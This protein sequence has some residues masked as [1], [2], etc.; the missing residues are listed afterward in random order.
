[1]TSSICSVVSSIG[2]A[3]GSFVSSVGTFIGGCLD[4]IPSIV[5]IIADFAGNLLQSLGIFKPDETPDKMGEKA[6]QAAEKGIRLDDFKDFDAYMEKLRAFEIDP[7]VAA[8]RSMA[9]KVIAGLG[10][11]TVG[12]EHKFGYEPGALNALW[13]LPIV[14]PGYFTPER[15]QSWVATGRFGADVFE[16]LERRL[17]LDDVGALR[18]RLAVDE[19]GQPLDA[20]RSD[21]LRQALNEARDQYENLKGELQSRG[22]QA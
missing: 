14:N 1:M 2:S 11:G 7:E 19:Q 10:V 18:N 12:L 15:V 5:G 8:K 6:L 22:G 21:E 20:A 9:E 3:L 16:Y 13:V 17:S 4:K